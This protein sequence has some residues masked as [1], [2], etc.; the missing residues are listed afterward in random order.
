MIDLLF[1]GRRL[2]FES[3][4]S[5]EEVT[6]RLQ[7][8]VAPATWQ[9]RKTSRQLFEGTFADGRFHMIRVVRGRNSFRPVIEGQIVPQPHGVRIDVQLRLHPLV[10]I[11]CGVLFTFGAG[12]AVIAVSEYLST[13]EPSPQLFVAG[14]MALVFSVFLVAPGVEAAKSTRLLANLFQSTPRRL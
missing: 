6:A 9:W 5:R 10:V 3:S 8:E 2:V 7:R 14:L 11:I 12:V 13:R 4:L 1:R